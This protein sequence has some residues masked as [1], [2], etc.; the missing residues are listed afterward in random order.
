MG[1]SEQG[2]AAVPD[3][4]LAR[5]AVPA[6]I[7]VA[8][9]RREPAGR[10]P[11]PGLSLERIVA[12]AITVA[13]RDGLA[14]LSMGRIATELG[15]APMSLY[16]YVR[17]K[18]ELLALMVDAALGSPPSWPDP[19]EGW[20]SGLDRWTMAAFD[21]YRTRSWTIRIP[22]S[23]PPIT[24]NQIRWL[25]WALRCLQGTG[26]S[27]QEQLSIV[28][29]LSGYARSQ[30]TM[31]VDFAEQLAA[32]GPDADP[33]AAAASYG[34]T[35][36]RLIDPAELPAVHAAIASGSLDDEYPPESGT[37]EDQFVGEEVRFGLER[38]LD[39]I[40][41]LITSRQDRG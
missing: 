33:A 39:G 22:I 10:G 41:V 5:I 2:A 40:E 9:G 30:A 8:W 29:L 31:S 23:G 12:A 36:A 3:G 20:R 14:A 4:V 38:I 1:E 17:A 35:L 25:E 28:L 15:S 11:R 7:E 13:E 6:S 34:R 37:H 27:H 26:L 21:V 24:P 18:G 16:R 32:A 19:D